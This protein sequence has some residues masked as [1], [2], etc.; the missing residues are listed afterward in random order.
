MSLR[1]WLPL[2]GDLHNQG[3]SDTIVTNN[4]ATVDNNGKIGKCYF[5]NGNNYYIALTGQK[6]FDCFKGG[7]TAFSICMWVYHADTRRA[8]LFGDYGLSNSIGFNIELRTGHGLR[9]YWNGSPDYSPGLNVGLNIWN[10]V[11]FTYDGASL[12]SY[13]NGNLVATRSGALAT[14]SKTAGEFRLG[15]DNRTTDTALNGKLNDIR[16]YGD[17]CLSAAEVKEIA[18]GLVLHYKL[19]DITNGIIQ[20]SSGYNHNGTITGIPVI[21]TDTLRYNHS[22]YLETTNTNNHIDGGQLP[23]TIQTIS[24][25][26]KNNGSATSY[27]VFAEP[28]SGLMFGPVGNYAVVQVSTS[29]KTCYA[30]TAPY[31]TNGDW[32]HIVVQKDGDNYKLWTNGVLR[33]SS[34]SNYYRHTGSNLWLFKRNYNNNYTTDSNISD[35]RAYTTLLS[36]SDIKQL[37]EIGAKVDNKQNLHTY[38]F[39]ENGSNKL[40]KTGI[41]KNYAIEP[42]KTLSDGSYWKLMLFHY[43]NNGNNLFTSSNATYNNGFGL[44]SRLRDIANY[45]YDSKYEY[46]VIQDGK[47]FRWT[48]TSSPTAAS[49]TGLTTVSGYNNPVNGLAKPS[50]LTQTYIGYNAWWGAC[51]CWTKYST[52]GKTGIPGFGSHDGNGICTNYLALYTRIEKPK[53]EIANENIYAENLIEF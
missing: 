9:F 31:Y 22:L 25:W 28:S 15:R 26:H 52:G 14:R 49:I 13:L 27:V 3:I 51:G 6:L 19:D 10:H 41:L 33:G 24:F 16:I 17:H 1:I 42:Y 8:I 44:Y 32:N 38:E 12:K 4:G 5:F 30:I 35:F 7:T 53:T 21:S 34:G 11:A 2:N 20:D 50:S 46:Y 45:T 37:Y 23:S 47:E 18:Q 40:T 39:N 48:Q 43:V 29:S 36:E